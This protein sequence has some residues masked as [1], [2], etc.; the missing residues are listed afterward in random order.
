[1]LKILAIRRFNL[2]KTQ[3]AVRSYAINIHSLTLNE[4]LFSTVH[5]ILFPFFKH[6]MHSTYLNGFAVITIIIYRLIYSYLFNDW[7]LARWKG[8]IKIVIIAGRMSNTIN[9]LNW[10]H[11]IKRNKLIHFS[12]VGRRHCLT[13]RKIAQL[14][15]GLSFSLPDHIDFGVV[16]SPSPVLNCIHMRFVRILPQFSFFFG[17]VRRVSMGELWT[18]LYDGV[19]TFVTLTIL[20]TCIFYYWIVENSLSQAICYHLFKVFMGNPHTLL[21]GRDTNM[22]CVCVL[23][24]DTGSIP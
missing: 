14:Y 19:G 17:F 10:W 8:G 1:M 23:I 15:H 3:Q 2:T 5:F 4:E 7:R 21:S 20:L 22:L 6:F 18:C 24:P 13:E 16:F 12:I 9:N 11:H